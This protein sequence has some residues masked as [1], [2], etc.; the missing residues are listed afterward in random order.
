[1]S[2]AADAEDKTEKHPVT[3]GA[4]APARELYGAMLLERGMAGSARGVR[5]DAQEGAEPVQRHA[6]A[7][8]AA[9]ALGDKAKA[10]DYYRKLVDLAGIADTER[11][12]L[13]AARQFLHRTNAGS[14]E[15]E[16]G[17]RRRSRAN[18][19]VWSGLMSRRKIVGL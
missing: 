11:P 18:K 4:P 2:A 5:G 8:K 16:T 10:K 6:G 12:D 14:P 9:E 15:V 3:P 19:K 1:M 13:A 17:F 7:A